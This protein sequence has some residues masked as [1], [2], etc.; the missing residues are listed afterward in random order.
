VAL[1]HWQR[2]TREIQDA[3]PSPGSRARAGAIKA[4]ARGSVVSWPSGSG[5]GNCSMAR[6]Q[7]RSG[8]GR[9]KWTV[10]EAKR[11]AS[12][13]LEAARLKL[14]ADDS[15]GAQSAQS[16]LP[17]RWQEG[18]Q[19]RGQGCEVRGAPAMR[20]LCV[21]YASAMRLLCWCMPRLVYAWWSPPLW[22]RSGPRALG[23]NQ[24]HCQWHHPTLTPTL[25]KSWRPCNIRRAGLG[26]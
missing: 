1:N 10:S 22:V 24:T 12:W 13:A 4:A 20:L 5:R 21:C 14:N 15:A 23:C 3:L 7:T 11:S 17:Q 8:P 25:T 26:T 16:S 18:S 6:V 2:A 19:G 9:A